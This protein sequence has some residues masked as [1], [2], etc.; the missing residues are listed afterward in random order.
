MLH[1]HGHFHIVCEHD[2]AA[3]LLAKCGYGAAILPENCL[4]V[5]KEGLLILPFADEQTAESS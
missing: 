5:S 3:V 2:Q 1:N 4:P